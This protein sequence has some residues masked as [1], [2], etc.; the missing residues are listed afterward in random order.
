M[1][2][3]TVLAAAT[4]APVARATAQGT[5]QAVAWPSR[6]ITLVV[7]FLAGGSADLL[8]RLLADRVAPRLGPQA[9]IVVENRG[10]AGGAIGSEAVR[11]ATPDGHALLIATPS[12]HATIPATQ[13]STIPYDPVADFS[14]IALLGQ[15]P[16][17]LAVPNGSPHRDVASLLADLRARPGRA[18]WGT[19]GAAG[20]G[21][22]TGELMAIS[23]GG[24][25]AEP[26]HYRGGSALVEAL[27][28]GELDYAW[29]SLGSLAP[30]ARDG[31]FRIIAVSTA[32][33]HSSVPDVP[34]MAESGLP[35]FRTSTW[36]ILLGPR[37]LPAEVGTRLNA[38][39]NEAMAEP[40]VKER[41]A[42]AGIDAV[43]DSTP[44]STAAF[45]A[46]EL[47]TYRDV[48]ARANLRLDRS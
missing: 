13:P 21:H 26:V 41:L 10:G 3:R 14:A 31:L 20:I 17:A 34:T 38:A 12:T 5:A 44:A 37:G 4:A 46:S 2:R 23:A 43:S 47:A 45:I 39:A 1:L 29:E 18:S 15:S 35:G 28:K 27:T 36:N 11:R 19:S 8:G 16:L 48:A 32:V 42:A 33:R 22:L 6:P 7:P 30:S 40:A 24:L 25:R 9:R